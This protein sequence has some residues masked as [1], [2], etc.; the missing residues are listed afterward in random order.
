MDEPTN[1]EPSSGCPICGQSARKIGKVCGSIMVRACLLCGHAVTEIFPL[2]DSPSASPISTESTEQ[3]TMSLLNQSELV[4]ARQDLMA[5]NRSEAYKHILGT[6]EP[7]RILE[8]G[9]GSG[10]LG[11]GF[12]REGHH[13]VG[14]DID[15]RPVK[16]GLGQGLNLINLDFMQFDTS[17]T[18]DVVT[19]SQVLE[20]VLRPQAF[21]DKVRLHL[22]P[23]GLIH[24]DVPN[25]NA[26][27]GWPSRVRRGYKS[28]LGG[29]AF[30]EHC[31]AYTTTSLKTLLKSDPA[32][33]VQVFTKT[34]DDGTWGQ[35]ICPSFTYKTYYRLS[36]LAN[37]RSLLVAYAVRKA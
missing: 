11:R 28:R 5:M 14:L 22:E 1:H 16:D 33:D 15:P 13:Y 32:F 24:L 6:Q 17:E 10:G 26:L 30:P 23:S 34:P 35:A 9:C 20:H 18:F 19:F 21:M 2:S 8:I 12:K 27:A 29:I 36:S 31:V 4:R 3:F 7:L 37:A 25:H